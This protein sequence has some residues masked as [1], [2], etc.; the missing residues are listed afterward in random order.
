MRRIL[1]YLGGCLVAGGIVAVESGYHTAYPLWVGVIG[2]ALF[3][4]GMEGKKGDRK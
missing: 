4:Y 2:M 3:F 1:A